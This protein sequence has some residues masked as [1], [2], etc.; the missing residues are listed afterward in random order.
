MLH[1]CEKFWCLSLVIANLAHLRATHTY[2]HSLRARTPIITHTLVI[3]II[4]EHSH[5]KLTMADEASQKDLSMEAPVE[6][7][8]TENTNVQ[9]VIST[10]QASDQRVI[11]EEHR[12]RKPSSLLLDEDTQRERLLTLRNTRRGH[13]SDVSRKHSDLN[14]HL[15]QQC[16]VEEAYQQFDRL[17]DAFAAFDEAHH[18]YMELAQ[19]LEPEE[20]QSCH[21]HRN[22]LERSLEAARFDVITHQPR[23]SQDEDN[24][25]FADQYD[26][27][28]GS[29]KGSHCG[30]H[31]SGGSTSSARNIA[32][33][34]KAALLAKAQ[35]LEQQQTLEKQ[36]L[37]LEQSM[38][39]LKLEAEIQA[40]TAE[41][42]TLDRLAESPD[43]R[44]DVMIEP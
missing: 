6:V 11:M 32:A 27:M 8:S 36:K 34:R 20:A 22:S 40:T 42:E 35:Y 33:S 30:T 28:E 4:I 18:R 5:K 38:E 17:K 10:A 21:D 14:R 43:K 37:S 23:P 2:Y 1:Y 16:S 24:K 9:D 12:Q 41:V 15:G 25:P 13:A 19:T 31:L 29:L 3:D 44:G 7:S 39:K 26:V